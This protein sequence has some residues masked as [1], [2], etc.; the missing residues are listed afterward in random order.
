MNYFID[1][2]YRASD[3]IIADDRE[4]DDEDIKYTLSPV[5]LCVGERFREALELFD[6]LIK[7]NITRADY[8]R[9]RV[10]DIVLTRVTPSGVGDW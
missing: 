3:L 8:I 6:F 2:M 7:W 10:G 4:E 5:K 9:L 1:I